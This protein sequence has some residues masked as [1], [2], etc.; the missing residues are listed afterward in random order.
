MF[1]VGDYIKIKDECSDR[2]WY[3]SDTYQIVS[4]VETHKDVVSLDR[5]IINSENR[6]FG[7]EI[8]IDYIEV[9]KTYQRKEKVLKL[10]E[11]TYLKNIKV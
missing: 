2:I 3:T 7:D 1:E 10:K 4:F 6:S 8:S 5:M 11:R 9:D